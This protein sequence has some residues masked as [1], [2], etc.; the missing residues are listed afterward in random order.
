MS[1]NFV[2]MSSYLETP[3]IRKEWTEN[4]LYQILTDS[5]LSACRTELYPEPVF[6]HRV[7][8]HWVVSTNSS[9]RCHSTIITDSDQHEIIDNDEITLPPVALL[10]TMDTKSLTCDRFFLPG[11]PMQSGPTVNIIQNVTI[12]PVEKDLVDF[13]LTLSNDSH[14][15][16]L[17]YI[18]SHIQAIIDFITSTKK[19]TLAHHYTRWLESP[20]PYFMTFMVP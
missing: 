17:P 6:V 20:I 16:K 4:Y 10:T 1:C 2:L 3:P 8:Q 5:I 9:T 13:H 12:N 19:M 18:P 11:L 7:G 14:W 15:A